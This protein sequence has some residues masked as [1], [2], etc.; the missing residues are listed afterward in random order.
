MA[1]FFDRLRSDHKIAESL[2]LCADIDERA[3][4]DAL[5]TKLSLHFSGLDQTDESLRVILG[6][7]ER[8]VDAAIAQTPAAGASDGRADN[9]MG[10]RPRAAA[11]HRDRWADEGN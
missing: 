5:R 11:G 2:K 1:D 9:T 7:R 10:P 8:P 6:Y 3:M 4:R